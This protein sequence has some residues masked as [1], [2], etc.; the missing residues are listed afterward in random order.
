MKQPL[1]NQ[2][3][4]CNIYMNCFMGQMMVVR[5]IAS[6]G[7]SI[8]PRPTQN[9]MDRSNSDPYRLYIKFVIPPF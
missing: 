2:N 1:D 3:I 6:V 7:V 4:T 8:I 5:P 9:L